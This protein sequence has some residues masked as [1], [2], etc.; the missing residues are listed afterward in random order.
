M[1]KTSL[2]FLIAIALSCGLWAGGLAAT[3]QR[4]FVGFG[5]LGVALGLVGVLIAFVVPAPARP[6]YQSFKH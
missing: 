4:S 3:K 6:A 2:A 1:D 5:L